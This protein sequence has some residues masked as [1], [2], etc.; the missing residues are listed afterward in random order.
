[1]RDGGWNLAQA[2]AEVVSNHAVDTATTVRA[3]HASQ[4]PGQ[5]V[6]QRHT[7]CLEP[8]TTSPTTYSFAGD[9]DGEAVIAHRNDADTGCG[10]S[11]RKLA[12]LKWKGYAE[13]RTTVPTAGDNLWATVSKPKTRERR[14]KIGGR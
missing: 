4:W 1:V 12:Q 10:R 14:S 6:D 3:M 5:V 7:N 8:D 9:G 11:G 2:Q 13:D